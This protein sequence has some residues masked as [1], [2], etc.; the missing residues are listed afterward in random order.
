MQERNL[1]LLCVDDDAD[2]CELVKVMF[3]IEGI[4]VVTSSEPQEAIR[5]VRQG[6]FDAII[7]DYRMP[8][9]DGTDVC[10]AIRTFNKEVPIVFFSASAQPQ[11]RPKILE[12]GGQAF[13]LKPDD[14]GNLTNA[15]I[16]LIKQGGRSAPR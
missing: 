16:E 9:I 15:V 10:R 2:S 6:N 11:E 5:L 8:E 14:L 1:T 4:E 12:S 7:L 3:R 13:L